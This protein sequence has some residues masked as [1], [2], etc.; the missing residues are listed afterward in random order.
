MAKYCKLAVDREIRKTDA[1]ADEAS[2]IHRLLSGRHEQRPQPKP[3]AEKSAS[4]P[5]G[6]IGRRAKPAMSK[7]RFLAGITALGHNV[8]TA[9]QLLGIGRSTIYRMASGQAAVPPVIAR[10][11]DMYERHGIPPEHQP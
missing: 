1:T 2:K 7:D 4:R 8:N 11:M 6:K 10:L 9:N 5:G 3:L